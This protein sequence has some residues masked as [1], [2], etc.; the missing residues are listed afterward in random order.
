MNTRNFGYV[1]L[2]VLDL[3]PV[4]HG[5][6]VEQAFKNSWELARNVESFGY[7]RFWLAEHH[8]M[9][10]IASSATSVLIGHI[11]SGTQSI[12]VGSGGIMLPNHSPLVIA[13]QFGT[14]ARLYP[15]RID[16]GIGRAPGTDQGTAMALRR[17][18]AGPV[19]DFPSNV[20]ELRGYFSE[21]NRYNKVRAIQAEGLN[22][23]VWLLGSST[24]SAQLSAYWG[25][26]FAFAS[27]FAPQMLLDSLHLYRE[28]FKPSENL[29]KPYAMAG[30][31]V[32]AAETDEE[33]EF[34]ATSLYRA[35]LNVIR[36]K[37][38]PLQAPVT[39][40]EDYWTEAEK[41]AVRQMLSYTFI[42]SPIT[43]QQKIQAFIN[44]TQIDELMV[45]AH[46]YDHNK[47]VKSFEL[48][49]RLKL[50]RE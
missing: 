27:H 25:L 10:G 39:N 29:N 32:I 44:A 3:V 2:S 17:N 7:N 28:N 33:A 49:S 20:Q 50:V 4:L 43:L 13:E 21:E 48:L 42:G 19:D 6:S 41:Y 23:P 40:M 47:R 11:A 45:G 9:A 35:F 15:N 37:G 18:L 46:I 31:N 22:V 36:G 30:I 34:L 14:L 12:R 24:Y 8:N 1:P 16:L 26:P 5:G 38:E